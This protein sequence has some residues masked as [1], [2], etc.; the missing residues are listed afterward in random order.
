MWCIFHRSNS[1]WAKL[2]LLFVL[3]SQEWLLLQQSTL[4]SLLFQR[5]NCPL[6]CVISR[7]WWWETIKGKAQLGKN[8]DPLCD[9]VTMLHCPM[10]LLSSFPDAHCASG[11]CGRG[12]KHELWGWNQTPFISS[13]GWATKCWGRSVEQKSSSSGVF[14]LEY[15]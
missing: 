1:Y 5:L 2:L 4:I 3:N 14:C 9:I 15:F 6:I 13:A 12:E 7:P 10:P 8:S 11:P